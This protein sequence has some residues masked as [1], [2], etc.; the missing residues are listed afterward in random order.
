MDPAAAL[1]DQV[2]ERLNPGFV[3]DLEKRPAFPRLEAVAEVRQ[4]RVIDAGQGDLGEQDFFRDALPPG[5]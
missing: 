2:E 4:R 3:E 1:A 5:G